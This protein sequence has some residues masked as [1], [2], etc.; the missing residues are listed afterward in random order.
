MIQDTPTNSQNHRTWPLNSWTE[1]NSCHHFPKWHNHASYTFRFISTYIYKMN[2]Y[3]T[4]TFL[5][6]VL[7]VSYEWFVII[8]VKMFYLNSNLTYKKKFNLL[9]LLTNLPSKENNLLIGN[10]H[11]DLWRSHGCFISNKVIASLCSK[12][13]SSSVFCHCFRSIRNSN[14][15]FQYNINLYIMCF[16]KAGWTY[17]NV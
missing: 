1:E 4:Q 10:N 11:W 14:I 2:T 7:L 9:S 12:F 17:L 8:I 5:Y 6:N 15:F 13:F 16:L 3:L